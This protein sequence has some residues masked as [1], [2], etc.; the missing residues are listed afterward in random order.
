MERKPRESQQQHDF[1]PADTQAISEEQKQRE[2]RI[3]EFNTLDWKTINERHEKYVQERLAAMPKIEKCFYEELEEVAQMSAEE[4]EEFRLDN[5]NIMV[6]RVF[7]DKFGDKPIPN[8]VRTFSEA[9]HNFP[10]IMAEIEKAGF[11]KPTPIQSQA[12][13]V[14]LKGEDLIGI[15]QTGTG[16]TLAF[17]L[18]ALIHIDG[19][20]FPKKPT[21]PRVLIMAPTRELALQ[22]EREVNKYNYKDIKS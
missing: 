16:K 1:A 11:E 17:L 4:V 14:L 13:P 15:A 2:L 6:S 18:P 8:P 5:N 21:E 9:L 12:F 7:V 20:T 10:L 3:Q 22:I 19:Q